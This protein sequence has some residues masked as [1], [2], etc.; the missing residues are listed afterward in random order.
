M[1]ERL[2]Q[3][4]VGAA[5]LVSIAVIFAPMVLEKD[6]R[7][8]KSITAS[9]VPSKPE[10]IFS[11]RILPV[12]ETE[13]RDPQRLPAPA[14]AAAAPSSRHAPAGSEASSESKA[15]RKAEPRPGERGKTANRA[16]AGLTAWAVQLGSFAESGNALGLRDRLRTKGYAAFVETVKLNGG[17]STRVYV[18]PEL[19]RANALDAQKR[20]ER[21]FG[22]K[23][24]V[25][26][27]PAG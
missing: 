18:G 15:V 25:V 8:E 14:A 21:E 22:M 12:Q 27:Y 16:E 10:A 2:K 3:R 24:L 6:S 11:S 4:L 19:L 1:D 7:P 17:K 9:N 20:L 26:R 5:V 13:L 23:G